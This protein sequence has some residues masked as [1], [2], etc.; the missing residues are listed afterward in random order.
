MSTS[1]WV[2]RANSREQAGWPE[3]KMT[4]YHAAKKNKIKIK[5]A[6]LSLLK[7]TRKLD[8]TTS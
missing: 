2:M 4:T 3:R 1:M 7:K 8:N 6:A 5:T